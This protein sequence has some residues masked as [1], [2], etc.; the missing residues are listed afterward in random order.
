MTRV[1]LWLYYFCKFFI[2]YTYDRIIPQ[3]YPGF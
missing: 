1:N 2:A 3:I